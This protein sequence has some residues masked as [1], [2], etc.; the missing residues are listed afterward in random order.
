MLVWRTRSEARN[1][2]PVFRRACTPEGRERSQQKPTRE[3]D[4]YDE[5]EKGGAGGKGTS[6]SAK[7]SICSS[8]L[9]VSSAVLQKER[10]LKLCRKQFSS[11][12][13][14]EFLRKVL[15]GEIHASIMIESNGTRKVVWRK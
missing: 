2:K 5:C 14:H 3:Y 10:P 12:W 1:L 8:L 13:C 15:F 9:Q 6:L 11:S 4:T 7:R